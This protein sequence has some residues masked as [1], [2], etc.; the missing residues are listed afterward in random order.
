MQTIPL[1]QEKDTYGK[2][3]MI[4]NPETHTT[5]ICE[6]ISVKVIDAVPFAL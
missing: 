4:Q 6:C 1:V 5:N 2:C 3:Q